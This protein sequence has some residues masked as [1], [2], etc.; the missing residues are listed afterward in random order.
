MMGL[1]V[2]RT[3]KLKVSPQTKFIKYPAEKV[4]FKLKLK[5]NLYSAIKFEDSEA[6]DDNRSHSEHLKYKKT[7][8]LPELCPKPR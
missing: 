2:F 6:L 1:G 7:V 4:K 8:W 5:T 3:P